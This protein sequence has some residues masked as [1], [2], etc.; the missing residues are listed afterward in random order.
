MRK[1][2]L[3]IR[4]ARASDLFEVETLMRECL[5][6]YFGKPDGAEHAA[7]H[8]V[9]E[10]NGSVETL[11]AHLGDQPAGFATF[12]IVYPSPEGRG[13]LFL[14][15][16]FVSQHA[17]SQHLGRSLMRHL[18]GIAVERNCV[19]FDWTAETSNPRALSFY[20]RLGAV[21]VEEKVYFRLDGE[22]LLAIASDTDCSTANARSTQHIQGPMRRA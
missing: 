3:T 17:R 14:K 21:R 1:A 4:A 11:I 2:G 7:R 15:D 19:R 22:R 6:H 13:T 9:P 12:A 5:V 18:A 8:M 16:L 10:E 20:D